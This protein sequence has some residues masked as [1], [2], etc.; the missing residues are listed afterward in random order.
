M[1][2]FSNNSSLAEELRT[3]FESIDERLSALEKS[4]LKMCNRLESVNSSIT[5][6]CDKVEALHKEDDVS[7]SENADS[8][9]HEE[10]GHAI[11]FLAAP[12]PDSVFHDFSTEEQIGKSI[13]VLNTDDGLSGSFKIIDSKDALATARISF[14]SFIKPVCKVNGH[15]KANI[16]SIVTLKEGTA[17]KDGNVWKVT[18]KAEIEIR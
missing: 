18:N 8:T 10:S 1:A 2:I 14:T 3:N 4:V 11:I 9:I 6:L 13:Y 16:E 15:P 12:A 7:L 5:E 17:V